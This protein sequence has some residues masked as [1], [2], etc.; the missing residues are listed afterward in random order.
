MSQKRRSRDKRPKKL[1]ALRLTHRDIQLMQ[2]VYE[3]RF[4]D[5]E[6]LQRLFF[7]SKHRAY[8]RLRLLYE[9]GFL[10][11][12]LRGKNMERMNTPLI[13]VLDKKGVA[14]LEEVL[15][16]KLVWDAR[17]KEL[18]D[19]FL[20][21]NIMVNDFRIRMTM[22]LQALGIPLL[23]WT[24]ESELRAN[25]THVNVKLA[26]DRS[27]RVA[28]IPDA[29]FQI[30][31][32]NEDRRFFLEVDMGTMTLKRFQTKVRA[33]NR[34]AELEQRE[35][36]QR[37]GF[38]VLTITPSLARMEHLKLATE[39]VGG[40]NRFWFSTLSCLE[41]ETV[42]TTPIWYKAQSRDLYALL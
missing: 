24:S 32:Q 5:T 10:D 16:E 26:E 27:K 33:Y 38:R 2:A 9:H 22:A 25:N 6:Q 1:A 41:V 37:P 14:V 8:E 13:Y 20:D 17:Q 35:N 31:V 29:Y 34:Y 28:L 40:K 7:P 23:S 42:L 4:L 15:K 19:F 11:R 21:H 36:T 3:Y 18:S 39:A 12:V 30:S